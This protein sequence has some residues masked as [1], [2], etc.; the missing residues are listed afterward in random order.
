[1]IDKK[2]EIKMDLIS[3]VMSVYNEKE[4]WLRMSIESILKQ[5]Y[6]NIEY[7]I[8]FDNPENKLLESILHEYET[9]DKRIRIVINDKNEGLVFSLNRGIA[10]AKGK[11]IARM[12]ADDFSV[13]ERL[14]KQY[15]CLQKNKIDFV[16]ANVDFL[17]DEEFQEGTQFPELD[18]VK[19]ENLMKY[20]NVSVH[21]TWFFKKEIFNKLNGYRNIEFVEDL[22]F[23]LRA[24]QEG[25]KCYKMLG[26]LLHY[27]FRSVGISKSNALE[28]YLKATYLR[29]TYARGFQLEDIDEDKVNMLGRTVSE[30]DKELYS[31][32]DLMMDDLVKKMNQGKIVDC[33]LNVLR[34]F[35]KNSF[36]R[37]LFVR[38]VIYRVKIKMM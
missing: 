5:T 25:F 23:V 7:I 9:Q 22:D 14:E 30:E 19:F 29:E 28:Q 13:P 8:V 20:G 12:D 6:S 10:L 24:I 16:M 33:F 1:M 36:Y 18:S 34:G 31:E 35:L 32:A 37:K 11:Y 2:D 38:N 26:H 4:E 17:Y 3:I 15:E 27:R 21:S